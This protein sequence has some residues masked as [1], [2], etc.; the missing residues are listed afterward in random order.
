M[1]GW[2]FSQ[3]GWRRSIAHVFFTSN[4]LSSNGDFVDDLLY[5]GEGAAI[6]QCI[7]ASRMSRVASNHDGR[8]TL[9]ERHQNQ[10]QRGK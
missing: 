7:A 8:S 9:L 5:G 3:P 4:L 1:C 2:R 6:L 10:L